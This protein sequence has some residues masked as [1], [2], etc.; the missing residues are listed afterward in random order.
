M[1]LRR[2][3]P[4]FSLTIILILACFPL[5]SWAGA[6]TAFGPETFT[7]GTGDPVTVTR[8]FSVLNPNTIYT[9]NIYNG[10][11]VDGEFE[12][13]SSSVVSLNSVQIVGPDGTIKM[14]R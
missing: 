13:V 1:K 8:S 5:P 2:R 14:S 12:K 7:R 4:I 11:L 10:G 9:L 3:L 6:F